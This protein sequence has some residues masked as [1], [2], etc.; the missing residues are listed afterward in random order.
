M[1]DFDRFFVV[2]VVVFFL[3]KAKFKTFNCGFLEA[4]AKTKLKN[5]KYN[6]PVSHVSQS[7]STFIALAPQ[8]ACSYNYLV[9]VM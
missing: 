4:A 2:V 9:S 3:K 5:F 8:K 1:N 7:F 6:F